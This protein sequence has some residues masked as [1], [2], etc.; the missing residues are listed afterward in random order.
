MGVSDT[1]W[2]VVPVSSD[3][4]LVQGV[5]TVVGLSL[6]LMTSV[7]EA[8]ERVE[9]AQVRA[10]TLLARLPRPRGAEEL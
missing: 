6:R 5:R 4:V 9:E 8:A 7:D 10:R 1:S 3:V 2:H